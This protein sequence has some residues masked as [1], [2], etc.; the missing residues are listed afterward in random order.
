MRLLVLTE[1]YPPDRGGMSESCDRILRGLAREGLVLDHLSL[2][3]VHFDRRASRFERRITSAGSLLR[4]PPEADAS[5]VLNLLWNELE[6]DGDLQAITHV[7]AFGGHLPLLGG[8]V[9]AA[10]MNKPLVTLIRGNE[11]DAGVFDPR[12]RGVLD[13]ALRR[14]AAVCTVTT[15]H[16]EKIAAL[17]EGIT[18]HVIANG[19]DF[20]LWEAT[21]ADIA[22]AA[23]IAEVAAGKRILGLFGH[24]KNKKG[25]P[26]FVEALAR[27]GVAE[28]FHL[29]LCGE[30]E[31]PGLLEA[32][33]V[34]HTVFPVMD[35]YALIPIYLTTDLVVVPSHYDGF[36]NVL[37]EAMAL[38][39]PL[40]ASTTGGMRDVLTD[41]G[42]AFLFA[43]GDVHACRDAIRRAARASG[44][45]LRRMGNAAESV[46]RARCDARVESS[47]Y[48]EVLRHTQE[49]ADAKR[50]SRP[51]AGFGPR[52][53]SWRERRR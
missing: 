40:L 31:S 15:S 36:P 4:V 5:H 24:L 11:L 8:P 26:F 32:E 13:D 50:D 9:F 17:H 12:R 29:L 52:E 48:L 43:P 44:E 42:D 47:R 7:V 21:E 2:D 22:R 16:A 45:E 23:K 53:L 3:V 39:R 38:A 30:V 25:L 18:P 20:D 27:S 6:R 34:S 10:W 37:I 41:G 46:A 28:E 33:G 35:R 14:S 51:D 49:A 19:I 1:T